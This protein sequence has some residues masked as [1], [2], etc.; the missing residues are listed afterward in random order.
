MMA[1]DQK[2][3]DKERNYSNSNNL[4]VQ[5]LERKP[6]EDDDGQINL[7][8]YTRNPNGKLRLKVGSNRKDE[9]SK[10]TMGSFHKKMKDDLKNLLDDQTA[11]YRIIQNYE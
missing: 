2:K 8:N 7:A 9:V 3:K 11:S 6:T 5:L 1:G 10:M 4:I